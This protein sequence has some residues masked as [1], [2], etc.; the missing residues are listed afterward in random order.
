MCIIA[1]NVSESGHLG[2]PG[3]ESPGIE[4]CL[5]Q[6]RPETDRKVAK[7]GHFTDFRPVTGFGTPLLSLEANRTPK[8]GQKPGPEMAG[9]TPSWAGQESPQR[10]QIG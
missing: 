7:S 9:D 3:A 5:G 10:P 4:W 6:D 2:V 8:Q 1:H